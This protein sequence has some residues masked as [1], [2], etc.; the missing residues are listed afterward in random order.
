MSDTSFEIQAETVL[1]G[2]RASIAS[3]FETIGGNSPA[4]PVSISKLLDI[5]MNLAWKLSNLFR[6]SDP[7]A[8]GKYVP[9]ESA[10]EIFLGSAGKKGADRTSLK[11]VRRAYA[12]FLELKEVHAGTRKELDMMLA[13][14]SGQGRRDAELVHRKKAYEA[15]GYLFGVQTRTQLCANVLVPSA[16][17]DSR[18]DCIRIRGHVDLRRI[19]PNVPWRIATSYILAE[20]GSFKNTP[21][22]EP[23]FPVRGDQPP[24]IREFTTSPLPDFVKTQGL[25]GS[26]HYSIAGG[27]VGN[28]SLIS[29]F[30]AEAVRNAGAYYA[31]QDESAISI[32]HISRTP[33]ENLVLDLFVPRDD[34]RGTV[35]ES[36][37]LSE[38]FTS[39]APDMYNDGDRLPLMEKPEELSMVKGIDRIPEV[40][41]YPELMSTVFQK[42]NRSEEDFRLFRLKVQYPPVPANIL[43]KIGLPEKD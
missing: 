34:F 38:L 22:R 24:V 32:S 40:P 41:L 4:R 8:C 15:N 25:G 1:T 35:P 30:T 29:V 12:A 3:V 28:T 42:L 9:G 36:E 27:S 18:L 33:S 43:M 16:G 20:N 31:D 6:N 26:C 19:R 2:L 23:L 37:M 21:W 14:L 13:S 17:D 7:F 39:T 5:D 11:E 10:M